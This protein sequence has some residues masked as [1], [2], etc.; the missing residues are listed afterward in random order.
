MG[1]LVVKKYIME[2]GQNSVNK[3]IDIGTPH[4]GSPSAFKTL[5]YGDDLG[6]DFLV[7]G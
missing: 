4:L 5:M 3:F 1:G 6:F 7:L 2:Y